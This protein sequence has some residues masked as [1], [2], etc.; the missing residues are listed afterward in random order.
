MI[1]LTAGV[2]MIANRTGKKNMIIWT[3][4]SGGSDAAFLISFAHAH[5]PLLLRKD[6]QRGP[7]GFSTSRLAR[8][9]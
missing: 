9:K 4:S 7:M 1:W 3:V 6:A 5:G 2:M 8:G